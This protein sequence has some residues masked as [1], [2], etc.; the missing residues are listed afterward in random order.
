MIVWDV[1]VIQI[2]TIRSRIQSAEF[3]ENN[4]DNAL[5]FSSRPRIQ[6]FSIIKASEVKGDVLEFG[7]LGGKS[8]NFF[9]DFCKSQ[10]LGKE[11]YGFDSFDGL[12]ESCGNVDAYREFDL[13][14]QIPKSINKGVHL[15]VG[16][17]HVTLPN[18][19]EE[20]KNEISFVHID[21]DSYVAARDIL[22]RLKPRLKVGALILFDDFHSLVGLWNYGEKRALEE[23]YARSQYEFIGFAPHQALI[24]L[25]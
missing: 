24:R 25:T 5:L 10:R 8:I 18:F 2:L 21:T 15:V 1:N 7:V 13:K 16:D 6:E 23:V 20:F 12:G 19:L 4:I 3:I 9:F 17:I 14:G 11:I 22:F